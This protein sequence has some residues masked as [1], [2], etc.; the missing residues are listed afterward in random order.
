LQTSA[1]TAVDPA[2][3]W[4]AEDRRALDAGGPIHLIF[5]RFRDEDL[6]RPHH[7]ALARVTQAHPECVAVTDGETSLTFA[8]LWDGLSGLAETIAR[9]E[10]AWRA[11]RPP[12]AGHAAVPAGHAGM[13]GLGAA[14]RGAGSALSPRDW[15]SQVLEDAR[16]ALIV[17]RE[18]LLAGVDTG[19]ARIVPLTAPPPPAGL[20]GGRGD[21]R[22][23]AG[24]RAVHLRQHRAAEGRGQQPAQ[25]AAAVGQSINAG[26]LNTDDR[27]LT[28]ASLATIVGVRDVVTALLGRRQRAP[29]SIRSGWARARSARRSASQAITVLFAFPALLRQVVGAGQEAA[30]AAL[31]LVR[32]GGDTTLGATSTSCARG[33]RRARRSS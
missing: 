25:P 3:A 5:R 6:D 12:A 1:A 16:P 4:L 32:V 24:L 10:P 17:S 22:G 18:A 7:R 9:G 26:H 23:R 15:V 13:P 29:A 31:R 2:R 21:G 19:A 27:F 11:D 14:V 30:G 20:G 8:E 33:S 28:L